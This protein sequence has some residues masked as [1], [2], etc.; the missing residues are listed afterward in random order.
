MAL[1]MADIVTA[2]SAE[3]D[4]RWRASIGPTFERLRLPSVPPARSPD[5]TRSGHSEAF[6]WL[7][8][9]FTSVR[10]IDPAATW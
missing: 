3:L 9:E 6:R 5:E 1:V 4:A 7:H 8:D 2:T 10:R